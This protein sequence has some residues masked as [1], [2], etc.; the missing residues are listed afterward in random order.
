MISEIERQ[1]GSIPALTPE[2]KA[3]L[4]TDGYLSYYFLLCRKFQKIDAYSRIEDYFFMVFGFHKYSDYDS[5]RKA[6][7][8]I[9]WDNVPLKRK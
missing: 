3:L 4:S 9:G 8:R 1:L 6:I 5:L 7:S 2:Q